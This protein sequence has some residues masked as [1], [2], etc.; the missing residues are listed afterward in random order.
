[1]ALQ[2]FSNSGSQFGDDRPMPYCALNPAGDTVLTSS[3]N[4]NLKLWSLPNCTLTR[5]WNGQLLR[6]ARTCPPSLRSRASDMVGTI[7]LAPAP[8]P[9]HRPPATPVPLSAHEQ[10]LSAAIFHPHAGVS[11][12]PTAACMASAAVDGAVSFWNMERCRFRRLD[13][14]LCAGLTS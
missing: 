13:G 4:G 6:R 1:M 12:P 3:W 2:A 11:L 5:S 14:V 9:P 8:L 10:R 7:A